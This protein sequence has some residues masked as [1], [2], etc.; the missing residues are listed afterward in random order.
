MFLAEEKSDGRPLP[1]ALVHLN[2]E[3][4]RRLALF[5][6]HN[7]GMLDVSWSGSC[8]VPGSRYIVERF[9]VLLPLWTHRKAMHKG[10]GGAS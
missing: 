4:P 6:Q 9:A 3:R 1:E 10:Q 5:L 7:D 2:A 8:P